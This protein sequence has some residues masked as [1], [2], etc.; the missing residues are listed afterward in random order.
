MAYSNAVAALAKHLGSQHKTLQGEG[1]GLPEGDKA[2][3]LGLASIVVPHDP[4]IS[5][6]KWQKGAEQKLIID[7]TAQASNKD[8]SCRRVVILVVLLESPSHP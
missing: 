3:P 6:A 8:L 1:E 7:I 5:T 4:R 2:I